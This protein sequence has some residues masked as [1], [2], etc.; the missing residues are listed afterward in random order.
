MENL[1]IYLNQKRK[2]RNNVAIYTLPHTVKS[3]NAQNTK[4]NAIKLR[5][6][7]QPDKN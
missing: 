1:N 2:E 3:D 6:S 5:R 7:F 4:Q